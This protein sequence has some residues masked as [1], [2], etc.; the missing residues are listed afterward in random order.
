VLA[1]QVLQ[2]HA[3][4]LAQLQA[5]AQGAAA[6]EAAMNAQAERFRWR[7]ARLQLSGARRVLWQVRGRWAGLW[8]LISC[9]HRHGERAQGSPHARCTHASCRCFN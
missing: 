7:S 4:L 9:I 3:T 2:Q 8:R 5:V 6:S 1:L